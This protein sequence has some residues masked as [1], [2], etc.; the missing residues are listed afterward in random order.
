MSLYVVA[1]SFLLL[2]VY[3]YSV[4]IFNPGTRLMYFHVSN[5]VTSRYAASVKG[6]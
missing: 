4:Y 5:I 2:S 3:I 1:I 6:E